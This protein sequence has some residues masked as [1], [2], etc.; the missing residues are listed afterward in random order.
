VS[1]ADCGAQRRAVYL[2][3]NTRF[4]VSRD[5]VVSATR[6]LQLQRRE[7]SFSVHTWDSAGK[8]HSARVTVSRRQH[9]RR[10]HHHHHHHHQQQQV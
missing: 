7:I 6:P 2:S 3:D 1:F 8:K 9:R 10:R 4:K 5:G